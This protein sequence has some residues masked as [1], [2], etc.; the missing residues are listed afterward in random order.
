MKSRSIDSPQN[1]MH[2][3][4]HKILIKNSKTK[5]LAP[6]AD[7]NKEAFNLFKKNLSGFDSYILDTGCGVGES[8]IVL[9]KRFAHSAVFGLDRS[10][11]RLA[12]TNKKYQDLPLNLFYIRT[13][14][15]DFWRLLKEESE[16]TSQL[17]MQ[18][19]YYPNPYPK[20]GQVKKRWHAHP[21]FKDILSLGGKFE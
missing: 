15:I 12:K 10:L 6:I 1:T 21:I 8:S 9:A 2:E 7:H 20:A 11:V 16:I 17:L 5:Y 13:D 19:F 18:C 14:L 3:N 4:L